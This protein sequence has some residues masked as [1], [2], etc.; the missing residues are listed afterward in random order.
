[1]SN[2]IGL[3]FSKIQG[4]MRLL[5]PRYLVVGARENIILEL[6]LDSMLLPFLTFGDIYL[7]KDNSDISSIGFCSMGK[8]L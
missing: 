8:Y 3:I 7:S 4:N 2:F 5:L 6:S 1:V